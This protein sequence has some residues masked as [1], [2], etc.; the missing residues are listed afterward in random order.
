VRQNTAGQV[1]EYLRDG[2]SVNLTG[3][4]GSGRSRLARVIR[5]RLL[6]H[7]FSVTYLVAVSAF[8]DRPLAALLTSGIEVP[9]HNGTVA[10]AVAVLMRLLPGPNS[11]LIIDDADE[12]DR[13]SLGA[14]T[15]AH[16]RNGFPVLFITKSAALH[17]CPER[18][19]S[20]LQ[21]CVQVRLGGLRFD[22]LHRLVHELLPGG[23]DS[24]SVARIATLSGGLPG[25]TAA[26][27][28]ICRRN[29]ML[30]VVD[31][32][33]Q[34]APKMWTP[35]LSA[36]VESLL[37]DLDGK[38]LDALTLLSVLGTVSLQTARTMV[39]RELLES[40]D[41]AG[42]LEVIGTSDGLVIGVYP[43]LVG[44]YLRHESQPTALLSAQDFIVAH[45]P[46]TGAAPKLLPKQLGRNS[47]RASAVLSR[48]VSDY[49]R[50]EREVLLT[51]WNA[52]K[53]PANATRLLNAMHAASA[54]LAEVEKVLDQTVLEGAGQADRAWMAIWSAI[55]QAYAKD[56]PRQAIASLETARPGLPGC[57]TMLRATEQH[58]RLAFFKVPAADELGAGAPGEDPSG[59][60]LMENVR[61]EA[62]LA[63]GR[64]A[65][66][67][68]RLADVHPDFPPFAAQA[69]IMRALSLVL[70]GRIDEGVGF[71]R[72]QLNRGRA[73]KEPGIIHCYGYVVTLGLALSGRFEEL[74]A[75]SATLLTL[76]ESSIL[77]RDYQLGSLCLT[78]IAAGWQSRMVY[79]R[80]LAAQAAAGSG[81][82][83][84]FP[85][86]IPGLAAAMVD[87]DGDAG[88]W[89]TV[90]LCLDRGCLAAAILQAA[91]AVER[92]VNQQV[93]YRLTQESKAVESPLLLAIVGYVQASAARD[94]DTLAQVATELRDAGAMVHAVRA[95]VKLALSQ[96][97]SGD[98]EAAVASAESAWAMMRESGSQCQALFAPLV[99][100][101]DLSNREREI[102]NL[103]NDGMTTAE[104]AG[105]LDLSV[106]TVENHISNMY[107]KIGVSNRTRLREV[108][109][110]WL[111][112]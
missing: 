12:L 3:L 88:L 107:R 25:P 86:M 65:E 52:A 99:N 40:L 74:D 35:E 98:L 105:V 5:E 83:G 91:A 14:I 103:T 1:I 67:D 72:D 20:E 34:L 101:V 11:V 61:I 6:Q 41:D 16:S 106:R 108:V 112:A 55:Y 66:A 48:H 4:P 77:Q 93:L 92:S 104:V 26:L 46:R 21:P 63:A 81:R 38:Q 59:E 64:T 45:W 8:R 62:L 18:G 89:D 58:L 84:A 87:P 80:A 22:E 51:T 27:I 54:N 76:T 94:L 111:A 28:D 15:S 44:E 71:A 23:V 10:G 79:A 69:D 100:E 102:A 43:P 70:A 49:W 78:A 109:T 33:W 29:G 37:A 7:G 95:A 36:A 57:D 24:N 73:F 32:M 9:Q 30:R 50:A 19:L 96:R 82:V 97:E 39:D 2:I 13:V 75:F 17:R 60:E 56:N 85:G 68:R 31:G 42:L 53:T 47:S 110:T 90:A